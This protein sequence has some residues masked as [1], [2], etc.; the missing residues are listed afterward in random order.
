[1]S[2]AKPAAQLGY[3]RSDFKELIYLCNFYELTRLKPS[4]KK[5]IKS[6]ITLELGF[7]SNKRNL[8]QVLSSYWLAQLEG[9]NKICQGAEPLSNQ[10]RTLRDFSS[11]LKLFVEFR[12]L[13]ISLQYSFYKIVRALDYFS[14]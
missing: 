14:H 5:I 1:L 4:Y 9:N 8:I 7:F 3:Y 10:I 12:W 2:K 11:F 13:N 6:P